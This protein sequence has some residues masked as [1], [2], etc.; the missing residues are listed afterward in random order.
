M[1]KN[2]SPFLALLFCLLSLSCAPN[3]EW[4]S[5]T[6][7]YFDTVCEIRLFCSSSDFVSAREEI[8]RLFS[9]IETHFSPG[10]QDYSSSIVLDLYHKAWA[11]YKNTNGC[12]DITIGPLT[13]IWG[14]LDKSYR[15]PSQEELGKALDLIGMDK[16]DEK[17]GTLVLEPQMELDWGGIAKGLAIDLAYAYLESMGIKRGFINAGGDLFCWGKNPENESWKIG[18]KH[19]RHQGYLGILTLSKGAAATT[20]DYQR[21]FEIDG[22]RYHHVFNPV[23]GFPAQGK[24]SV[25]VVGPEA[26]LCDALSTALFVCEFPTQIL[27]NYP[28]YGAIIVNFEGKVNLYG[29]SYLF[30]LL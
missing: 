24:Q 22:I 18:I 14:F 29:K 13:R 27:K 9:K 21:F 3:K 11:V 10:N 20:G 19:P 15:I 5:A 6:L 26:S 12:F 4:H 2:L 23:T 25:T 28:H 30:R 16:I 17:Q 1:A 7:V 8:Q